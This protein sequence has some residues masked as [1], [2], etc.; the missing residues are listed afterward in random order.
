VGQ[1]LLVNPWI[2][3]FAAYDFGIRPHG[4]LRI[5]EYLRGQGKDIRLIDCL[6][7]CAEKRDKYGFSKIKKTR[8]QKPRPILNTRRSYSRYGIS[9]PEFISLIEKVRDAEQIYITSGMTY[10]YPGVHLAI[11][12]LRRRFG[13][14]PII[15]G[16]IYATLC[17][18]HASL[19]AGADVVWKGDYLRKDLFLEKEFYPAYDL[20]SDTSVL[21]I[22]LTRGCPFRC[23]YCASQLLSPSYMIKD[24]VY[25]FEEVM[26][27]KR[28]F[29]TRTLVFYDDALMYGTMGQIKSFLRMV[30]AAGSPF[31]FQTPNGIHAKYIDEELAELLKRAN[32]KELRLSLETSDESLQE[33][34][35]GKVTN[36]D[37]K[38]ALRNLKEAGFDKPDIGVY[39]LIGAPWLRMEKTLEDVLFINSLGAKAILASYSPIPGTKD[40]AALEENGIITKEIDP[41]WHNKS[42]FPDLLDPSHTNHIRAIRDLTAQLNKM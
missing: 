23:S 17:Y 4:L 37:V 34:T 10:W 41:L 2:Y 27:Y 5:G 33:C 12:L 21:P 19:T 36:T 20:L 26:H 35:G 40:Y 22:R 25:L 16:G 28:T 7:G 9:V 31:I 6:G 14:T 3:D 8:V 1:V 42:V 11:R 39:L 18:E 29:G 38:R 13:K 32:F 24:P 15:L 30:I